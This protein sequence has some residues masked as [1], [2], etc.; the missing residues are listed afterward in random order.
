[1]PAA[2]L[3]VA[4]PPSIGATDLMA[5]DF[6][7]TSA[8]AWVRVQLPRGRIE[9]E[10]V[11]AHARVGQP[12]LVPGVELTHA[13]TSNQAGLAVETELRLGALTV[14]V[15]GGFASGDDAPGFGAFPAPGAAAAQ[16]GDLDGPQ[17]DPP[18]D[19]TVDNFR[20]H[21]D[22][23]VDRILFREIIGT[24][25]DATYLRPHAGARLMRLGHGALDASCALIASWAIEPAS[26]PGNARRLGVELDPGLS[27]VTRDGLRA[28][29]EYALF[30][31]GPAFDGADRAA[32]VA[33]AL[34]V[35]L[36]YVF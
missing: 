30:L 32:A 6:S 28:A 12:S 5:R 14:G 11:Y 31:P 3:Q 36:A 2:Y 23:H 20:F 13:A 7:A 33:Q 4:A 27:F 10:G 9:A 8:G 26:T 18:G 21:P 1:M 25:T 22:Y 19:T 35:R 34:R 24:V 16:P 29:L 15:D 17:A